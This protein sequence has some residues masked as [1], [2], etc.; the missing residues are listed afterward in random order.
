M[1]EPMERGSTRQAI[2]LLIA[3]SMLLESR[4]LSAQG[5]LSCALG[6]R[7]HH[8]SPARRPP[9]NLRPDASRKRCQHS[10][11]CDCADDDENWFGSLFWK[12]GVFVV[13]A[14]FWVP[15][16]LAEDDF[17]SAGYFS[18]YPYQHG[19]DGYMMIDPWLPNETVFV[20][21]PSQG[22]E[23]RR[24]TAS[25][26]MSARRSGSMATTRFG[27]DREVDYQGMSHCVRQHDN[28]WT[29]A[30][31]SVFALP[32]QSAGCRCAPSG[33]GRLTGDQDGRALELGFNFTYQGDFFPARS[34]GSSQQNSISAS[35]ETKRRSTSAVSPLWGLQSVLGRG[36]YR[37]RLL[38]G[39]SDRIERLVSA[40]CDYR[41][42]EV[43]KP[44][45]IS[46]VTA[47][48]KFA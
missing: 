19:V 25:Q 43:A 30:C 44:P 11:G 18:E 28:F 38:R 13:G 47:A 34:G 31:E 29:K 8:P 24:L 40:A 14:P 3:A 35:W 36:V 21:I 12:A 5:A 41:G 17:S 27:I 4:E 1:G 2:G 15:A 46:R 42:L 20:R 48:P 9:I 32:N 6:G 23:R 37:L 22:R 45:T 16:T 33:F 10:Y 26:V 39:R 7:P